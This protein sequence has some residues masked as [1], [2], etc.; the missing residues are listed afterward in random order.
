MRMPSGVRTGS[1][2][3]ICG[4]SRCP[5][6]I[7]AQDGYFAEVQASRRTTALNEDDSLERFEA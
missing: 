7:V 5:L 1:S 4:G 2:V 3:N 6:R